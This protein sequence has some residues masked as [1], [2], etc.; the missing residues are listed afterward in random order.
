MSQQ[1]LGGSF[2]SLGWISWVMV[3]HG[4]ATHAAYATNATLTTHATTT[5]YA[6][7]S[8]GTRAGSGVVYE[9]L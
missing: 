1:R 2:C 6:C 8:C 9:A 7:L 5:A 4:D 3:V